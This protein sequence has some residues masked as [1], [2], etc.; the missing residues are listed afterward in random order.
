MKTISIFLALIN[1][2]LAGLI[3]AL[4]LSSIQDSQAAAWWSFTRITAS[5]CVILIAAITWMASAR[6]VSPAL[7]S[8][9]SLMLVA[10]GAATTV[11]T[12]HRAL[13]SGDMEY[14]MIVYGGSL[15]VQGMSSLFGFGDEP[16]AINSL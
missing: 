7:M 11:W 2:L 1:A 12:F 5:L 10:L 3:L 13:I 15:I 8:V 16:R 4:S 6:A 9:C 14:Y